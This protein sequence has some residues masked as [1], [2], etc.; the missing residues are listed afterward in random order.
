VGVWLNRDPGRDDAT[1]VPTIR[2]LA[3]LP[4]LI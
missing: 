3:E 2:S 4:A 1:D